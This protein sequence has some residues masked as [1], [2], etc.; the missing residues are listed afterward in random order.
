MLKIRLIFA[1]FA[2]LISNEVFS[3]PLEM[4]KTLGGAHF[5]RDTLYLSHRQ[6]SEI[7]SIDP[8]A[9]EEFKIATKNYRIG[10]ILGFSGAILLAIPVVTAISGGEPEW[11]M[12][13][14]GGALLL[15]SIPFSKTFK[16]RSESAIRVYNDRHVTPDGNA[17]A[18]KLKPRLY[19]NGAGVTLKF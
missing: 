6:V 19:F 8:Q 11:L 15:A 13:G 10:G 12:A 17:R 7:L 5:M 3:Q 1:L 4:H 16:S 14:A 18:D 9:S 2:I